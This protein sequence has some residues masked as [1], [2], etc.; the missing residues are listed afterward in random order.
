MDGA[1]DSRLTARAPAVVRCDQCGQ[2][3]GVHEP[4]VMLADGRARETPAP[5]NTSSR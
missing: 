3:I 2:S 1:G 5:R 4:M